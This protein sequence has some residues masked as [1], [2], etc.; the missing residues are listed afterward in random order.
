[1]L[2]GDDREPMPIN[3]MLETRMY[4]L[5]IRYSTLAK[6]TVSWKGETILY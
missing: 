4:R 2:I 3:W 1:M 6:G 5:H